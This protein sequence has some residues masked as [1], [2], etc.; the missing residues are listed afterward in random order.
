M[1]P[2]IALAAAA[3][4]LIGRGDIV[5][6]MRR[7]DRLAG[8]MNWLLGFAVVLLGWQ[9]TLL[10]ALYGGVIE[11][12]A[13]VG[14]HFL[15]CLVLAA[16]LVWRWNTSA[17]DD[18]YSAALQIVAWSALA[19]PFGAFVAAALAFPS[20]PIRVNISRDGDIDS[21]TAGCSVERMHIALLDRRVRIDGTSRIRPLMDVIAEG[22]Q[23]E[24]LEALGIVYRRYEARLSAVLKRALRDPH[25][26]VRVLAATVTAKLHAT[27]SRKVGDCQTAADAKPGVAQNWRNL[28]EARFAY[29]ESGLLEVPRARVQ[30]EFAIDDLSR[31][32]DLDP[33]DRASASR[34]DMARRQL[35]TWST[36]SPPVVQASTE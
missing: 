31:A 33:A 36:F 11:L 8:R 30:I 2:A 13:Y 15:G 9:I 27:Y 21:L 29:A 19:G 7:V 6:L 22:S 14:I 12:G 20:A 35:V 5:W 10:L 26:S 4:S 28:A 32:T 24:K 34:L 17:S 3:Q 23:A 25:M 16:R 18:G 1:K